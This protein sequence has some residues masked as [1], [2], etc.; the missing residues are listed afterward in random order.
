MNERSQPENAFGLRWI[1]DDEQG[2]LVGGAGGD[3]RTP[4]DAVRSLGLG[5]DE[6]ALQTSLDKFPPRVRIHGGFLSS[7]GEPVTRF[8][9]TWEPGAA[10]A[11]FPPG[12][13]LNDVLKSL[14]IPDA[15]DVVG[16]AQDRGNAIKMKDVDFWIGTQH[17]AVADAD[18]E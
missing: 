18:L 5:C 9:V 3:F 14:L 12:G 13:S 10:E 7:A 6:A 4:A 17:F 11:S 1:Q 8:T 15:Q 16:L 2:R